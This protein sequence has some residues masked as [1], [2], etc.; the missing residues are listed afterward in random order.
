[1]LN[2]LKLGGGSTTT[3][4]EPASCFIAVAGFLGFLAAK[5]WKVV[6]GPIQAA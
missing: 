6:G 4:P 2:Q 1:L 3:V 5:R